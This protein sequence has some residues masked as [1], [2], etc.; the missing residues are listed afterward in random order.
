MLIAVPLTDKEFDRHLEVCKTLGADIVEL[1]VDM[2]ENTK[3][4]HVSKLIQKAH[5]VGLMTI[6]TIRS[7]EEGGRKVENREELFEQVAPLS[8]YT[9]VE[10]SSVSILSKVRDIIKAHNRT[11]II[12]YH[13]FS[14][15]PPRWIL[16]EVF[17]SARRWGADIVKI[18]VKANSYKDVAELLCIGKEEEGE[19][20]LISMGKMGSIS[21]LAGFVFGSVISYAF[22][23]KQVAEGQIHLEQMTKLRKLFYG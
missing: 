20:I 5:S 17:R 3:V 9:D 18:A 12:S 7:E 23:D 16:R 11:L 10:L 8:H 19:K 4:E 21:R 15:T 2:F 13:N 22:I 6:L 1:R 14:A